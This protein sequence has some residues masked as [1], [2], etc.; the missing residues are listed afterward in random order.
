MLN[1]L[2]EVQNCLGS[3]PSQELANLIADFQQ[4]LHYNATMGKFF[5]GSWSSTPIDPDHPAWEANTKDKIIAL[6]INFSRIEPGIRSEFRF[7][8]VPANTTTM[9]SADSLTVSICRR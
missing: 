9:S 6:P 1:L 4:N 5:W 3:S 8:N 7:K 2:T